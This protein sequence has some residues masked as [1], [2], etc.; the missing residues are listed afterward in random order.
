MSILRETKIAKAARRHALDEYPKESVGGI[1]GNRYIPFKNI[2]K[3]PE[4]EFRAEWVEGLEALVHSHPNG[5][6]TPSAKDIAQQQATAIP[7]A[8]ITVTSGEASELHWFGQKT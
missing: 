5:P 1:I 4:L 8:I 2:A 6:P 7:W 3:Q